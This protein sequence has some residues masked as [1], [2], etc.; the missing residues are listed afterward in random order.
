LRVSDPR[1]ERLVDGGTQGL[2][3]GLDEDD[4]C[5]EKFHTLQIWLLAASVDCTH[6]DRAWKAD[7][8]RRCRCSDT[9]LAGTGLGNDAIDTQTSG[10]QGL[11][12]R[13]VDLVGTGVAEVLSFQE[14]FGSPALTQ[15]RRPGQRGRPT[16]EITLFR[17]E[18]RAK[19]GVGQELY[20]MSF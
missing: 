2:V 6:V 11:T 4:I 1:P 18:L 10:Y 13:I 5:A 7:S 8:R 12:D 14:H 19:P 16:D 15:S 17:L 3:S 9:V 20:C